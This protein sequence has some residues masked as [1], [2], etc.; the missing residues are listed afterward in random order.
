MPRP[1]AGSPIGDALVWAYR[2][3]GVAIAMFLPAVVGSW[4]DDRLGTRFLGGLGLVV[5]FTGG[6]A[7]LIRT[8]R[9]RRPAP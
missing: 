7:A 1:P 2:I 9:P 6:L 5:G 3:I 8:T 4:L